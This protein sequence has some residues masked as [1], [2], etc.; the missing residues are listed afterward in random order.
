MSKF[1]IPDDQLHRPGQSTSERALATTAT[2]R[3]EMNK[4]VYEAI[5]GR[6]SAGAIPEEIVAG[7]VKQFEF[8]PYIKP[9]DLIDVRRA[10]SVLKKPRL[11]LIEP[12]G[13]E[14]QNAKGNWCEVWRA[15]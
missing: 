13:E 7:S 12:T 9:L 3:S 4:R 1:N 6:G 10:F 15:K 5:K 2:S 8:N 11:N 14:R